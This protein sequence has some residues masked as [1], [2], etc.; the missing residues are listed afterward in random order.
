MTEPATSNDDDLFSDPNFTDEEETEGAMFA[1]DFDV[2]LEE[3]DD[4]EAPLPVKVE[5][6]IKLTSTPDSPAPKAQEPVDE[7][8]QGDITRIS[9]TIDKLLPSLTKLTNRKASSSDISAF[10]AELFDA[11]LGFDKFSQL[12]TSYDRDND[13]MECLVSIEDKVRM[14]IKIVGSDKTPDTIEIS[15]LETAITDYKV[16]WVITTNGNNWDIYRDMGGEYPMK[17]S[18]FELADTDSSLNA[19]KFFTAQKFADD[20]NDLVLDQ[21]RPMFA[22][23]AHGAFN[24][25]SGLKLIQKALADEGVSVG[26]GVVR[27]IIKGVLNTP[28]SS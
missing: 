17:V 9:N 16:G 2:K 20:K 4:D 6:E 25:E 22:Q 15:S 1:S 23:I 14:V 10:V 18:S 13:L 26:M 3:Y 12:A 19:L 27:T 24:S 28:P 7:K 8:T 5:T 11:G 21:Y